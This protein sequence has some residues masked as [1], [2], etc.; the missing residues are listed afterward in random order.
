[1]RHPSHR[2]DFVQLLKHEDTQPGT[3]LLQHLFVRMQLVQRFVS[4]LHFVPIQEKH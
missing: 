1:M 2:G 4:Q 3:V